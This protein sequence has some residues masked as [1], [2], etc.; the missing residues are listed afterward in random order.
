MAR[1]LFLILI[2]SSAK[3]SS[4]PVPSVAD[5]LDSESKET[6]DLYIYGLESGLEWAQERT[7]AKNGLEFFCKPN[8]LVLSST[9]IRRLID[10]EIMENNSFYT[11]YKDAP[12]I[13]LALRNAYISTFPCN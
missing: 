11:K 10:K 8:D 1:Y 12:L 13:G 3:I 2:L 9:Q 7:Y 4:G 5:Y 6:Y